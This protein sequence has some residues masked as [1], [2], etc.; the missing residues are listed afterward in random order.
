MIRKALIPD[1]KEIHRLLLDYARDGLLLS[2]SL[3]ELYESLRDFYVF[4]ADGKVVVTAMIDRIGH[5]GP[6]ACGVLELVDPDTAVVLGHRRLSIIDLST[7]ADQPLAKDGLTLSYNGELY[8]Y[9]DLRREL[10]GRGVRFA[11][12]SDTEVVLEAWRAWGTAAPWPPSQ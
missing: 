9:L 8:N 10:E 11:T 1:V 7:A 12:S 4:E 6:D 3:A 5:R 2:R